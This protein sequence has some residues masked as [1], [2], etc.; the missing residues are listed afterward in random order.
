MKVL[1]AMNRELLAWT[2][3]THEIKLPHKLWPDGQ[4]V[5]LDELAA[6]VRMSDNINACYFPAS[7]QEG[8]CPAAATA[9]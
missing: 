1:H 8:V 5:S 2:R 9:K 4:H 6:V 3:R 7:L